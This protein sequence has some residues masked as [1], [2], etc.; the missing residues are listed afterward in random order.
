MRKKRL[1]AR[2]RVLTLLL[3]LC[4][5][6]LAQNKIISGKVADSKDGS[7]VRGVSVIP[8]GS[9]RGTVTDEKGE[10]RISR[11]SRNQRPWFF[12]P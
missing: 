2:T 10:F 4:M 5:P 1:L 8:Q 11:R 9:V 7:P 6:A 12:L 3:L